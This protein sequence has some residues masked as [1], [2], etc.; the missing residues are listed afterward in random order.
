MGFLR[1]H[2]GRRFVE[3]EQK[4]FGGQS[5]GDLQTPLGAVG[6]VFGELVGLVGQTYFF[7][8]RIAG[9]DDLPALPPGSRD[10]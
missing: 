1:V 8:D 5:P 2:A 10:F 6:Q 9:I 3:E 4:R 7:Q